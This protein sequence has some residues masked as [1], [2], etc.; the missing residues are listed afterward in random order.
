MSAAKR[1]RIPTAKPGELLVCYGRPARGEDPDV[2]ICW[3]EGV[4]K[5]DGNLAHYHLAT[6]RPHFGKPQVSPSFIEELHARGYDIT[7]L[8]LSVRKRQPPPDQTL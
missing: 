7:T 4:S 6:E 5:R 8:K 3:G 1:V 2:C